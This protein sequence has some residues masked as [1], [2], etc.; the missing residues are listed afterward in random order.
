M[1]RRKYETLDAKVLEVLEDWLIPGTWCVWYRSVSG[2]L[3]RRRS[4]D[5]PDCKTEAEC[6]AR[7]DEYAAKFK[8]NEVEE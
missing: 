6:Q 2:A 8:M 7:L 1:T 3:H 4:V 5:L